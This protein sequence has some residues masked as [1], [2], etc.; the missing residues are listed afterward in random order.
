M[1]RVL[2]LLLLLWCTAATAAIQ[3]RVVGGHVVEGD[4]YPWLAALIQR[5]EVLTA[6]GRA[7]PFEY[8]ADAPQHHFSGPLVYCGAGPG[9]C[10]DAN[11]RVCLIERDFFLFA[12]SA[13]SRCAEGG[14]VAAIIYNDTPGSSGAII[15]GDP[16][17]IPAITISFEDGQYLLGH[18]DET[19][20]LAYSDTPPA[21]SFCGGTYL[22]NGDGAG[23][24]VTAAHCL[25]D[26]TP[27]AAGLLV[28]LGSD[29]LNQRPD[30]VFRVKSYL[31]HEAFD[32]DTLDND[33]ALLRLDGAPQGI[34]AA[35]L[36]DNATLDQA[37]AAAAPALVL[38]RGYHQQ[39][40]PDDE[41][42]EES[43][44][45]Q[46]YAARVPLV[47]RTRCNTAYRDYYEQTVGAPPALDP[48]T[49]N[50]ICAGS[51]NG[52]VG[53]CQG[54][55]GGP[56]LVDDDAGQP[57]LAGLTSWGAGCAAPGLPG[58]YTR[59]PNY[60][61]DIEAIMQGRSQRL[62]KTA[63]LASSEQRD[64]EGGGGDVSP[65]ALLALLALLVLSAPRIRHRKSHP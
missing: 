21:E 23:W 7:I 62:G 58:V 5:E 2:P 42:E 12:D 53:T 46:G 59:V 24:V 25:R 15:L 11:N 56:L 17:P 33:I 39:R 6:G 41:F 61:R 8:V 13:M 43:F 3:P 54:D 32:L 36:V 30:H 38:G 51:D 64:E 1:R 45:P 31:V 4:E 34:P 60:A 50:M 26:P 37:I 40:G 19:A 20:T 49:P 44:D 47:S 57:R 9:P 10:P 18:L 55:S 48:I 35:P 63:T 16:P 28:Y 65:P 22:G 52:G 27:E 29:R 14:G